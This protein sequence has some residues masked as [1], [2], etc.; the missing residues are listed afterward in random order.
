VAPVH[1]LDE[2]LRFPST[3][4]HVM[5]PLRQERRHHSRTRPHKMLGVPVRLSHN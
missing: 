2:A 4:G 5:C 3:V 1:V